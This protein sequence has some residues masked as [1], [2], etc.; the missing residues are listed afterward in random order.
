M[1]GSANVVNVIYITIGYV[2]TSLVLVYITMYI[3]SKEN[4]VI[5]GEISA[6]FFVTFSQNQNVVHHHLP[7]PP[8]L[9]LCSKE[10]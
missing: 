9:L 3:D 5:F 2:W 10:H 8:Q 7:L 6:A 1:E 4:K